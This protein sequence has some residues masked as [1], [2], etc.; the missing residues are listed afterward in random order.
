MAAKNITQNRISL[1]GN[2][3]NPKTLLYGTPEDVKQE[4]EYAAQAGVEILAPECAIPTNVPDKNLKAIV[5]V[6]KQYS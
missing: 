2:V 4:T 6:A 5:K 3:N 1:M